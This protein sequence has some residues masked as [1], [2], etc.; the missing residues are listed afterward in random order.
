MADTLTLQNILRQVATQVTL[1]LGG[2][3]EPIQLVEH[4]VADS[5]FVALSAINGRKM[6]AQF[7]AESDGCISYC[8]R[9]WP[10]GLGE[11]VQRLAE[12]EIFALPNRRGNGLAD[13]NLRGNWR[14]Y[15]N[16]HDGRWLTPGL[17]RTTGGVLGEM[18]DDLSRDVLELRRQMQLDAQAAGTGVRLL[19]FMSDRRRPIDLLPTPPVNLTVRNLGGIGEAFVRFADADDGDLEAS[20]PVAFH[21]A[22]WRDGYA[23]VQPVN[24]EDRKPLPGSRRIPLPDLSDEGLRGMA[25]L[26]RVQAEELLKAAA[27][28]VEEDAEVE[29][30]ADPA[31]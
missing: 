25:P 21:V 12:G 9:H 14:H 29:E 27:G 11:P 1:S 6:V 8:L 2:V 15:P 3:K 17:D 30:E 22:Y 26:V 13:P 20:A 10:T 19:A 23:E 24:A 5:T 4:G 28:E 16:A 18:Y 31:P 7:K